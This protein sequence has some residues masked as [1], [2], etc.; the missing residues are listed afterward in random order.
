MGT[1]KKIFVLFIITLNT[2]YSLDIK[3][4]G[5]TEYTKKN[6]NE[7]LVSEF[8]PE[9]KYTIHEPKHK[10]WL[11]YIGGKITFDYNHFNEEIKSNVFTVLG[12]D[13]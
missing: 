9:Y 7:Q 12:I 13:F 5:E 6:N 1:L 8:R 10:K 11:L 4:K 2:G 3:F